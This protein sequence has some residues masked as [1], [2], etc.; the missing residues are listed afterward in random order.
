MADAYEFAGFGEVAQFAAD[1]EK[2]SLRQ[3]EG[4]EAVHEVA[5]LSACTFGLIKIF[6]LIKTISPTYRRGPPSDQV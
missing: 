3:N 5:S 1:I 4:S 2:F 6:T